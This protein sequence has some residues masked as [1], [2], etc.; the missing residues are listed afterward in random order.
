MHRPSVIK[1]L[2]L[3]SVAVAAVAS[4]S[5]EASA[6]DAADSSADKAHQ[7]AEVIV[8]AQKREQ[9]VQDVGASVTAIGEQTLQLGGVLDPTRLGALV[10]GMQVGFSGGEAR[11]A[12]R[13]TRTNDWGPEGAQVVGVFNDGA[14]LATSTQVMASYLDL[15]RIEVL[16]GPQGTLYGRNTFAGAINIVSNQPQF[17]KSEGNLEGEL[18]SYNEKRVAGVINIPVSDTFALRLSGMGDVRDGYVKNTY[19]QDRNHDLENQNVY[20]VR[21]SA[22]WKPTEKFDATLRYTYSA[23]DTN[24][25]AIWGYTQKACYSNN[26]DPTTATGQSANATFHVGNCALPGPLNPIATGTTGRAASGQDKGPYSVSRDSVAQD[27]NTSSSLNLQAAYDLGW[28]TLKFIGAYD[29]FTT[30]QYYDTD[31]SDGYFA[32]SDSRNNGFAGYDSKQDSGSAELQLLSKDKGPLDWLVG[33]YYFKSSADW[34][35]GYLNNGQYTRYDSTTQLYDTTSSAV[36]GNIG[37]SVTDKFKIIAGLRSNTDDQKPQYGGKQTSTSKTLWK[38][39]A[40]YKY[41]KD[42]LLYANASTGY[43]TGGINGSAAV[44]KGAPQVFGPETVTA[45]EAGVKSKWLAG[46]LTLNASV[47]DNQYRN[48]QAQ[49]FVTACVDPTKPSTC[50]ATQYTSNGG[51]IDS[52]GLELE[53]AWH[54]DSPFFLSG[55]VTISNAEFGNYTISQLAGLGNIQG[56]QDVTQTPGVL[57]AAGKNAGLSLKGWRPGMTPNFTATT[58]AGYEFALGG[59]NFLTPQIQVAYVGDYWSYDINVPGSQQAA[60]TKTDLR[61]IWRNDKKGYELEAFVQNIEDKAVL[62]RSVVFT[63]GD[64]DK[65]VTSIQSMYA[66][67]RTWGVRLH[68]DF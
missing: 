2:L 10:P 53:Y 18:G 24:G 50:I 59:G 36:F 45:Y 38:A 51:A 5:C 67:P 6:A 43:R 66:I 11:I 8:T 25:S 55:Q 41:S 64:G 44:S 32:G 56:R 57:A 52:K 27:K 42:V 35:Y 30:L 58:Q 29:K 17:N 34:Q 63:D 68:V 28:S 1:S 4:F 62:T 46:A 19:Y 60:Y 37:Y 14:Y 9:S 54:P 65:P 31:Y 3:T 23:Q 22:R 33:A 39:G 7:V 16:R 15:N 21:I 61:L 48:M 47:Y 26:L 13:G 40:E 12:M 20:A 49:S